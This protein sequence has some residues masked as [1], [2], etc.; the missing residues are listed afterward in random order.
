VLPVPA[1]F[2]LRTPVAPAPDPCGRCDLCVRSCPVGALAA[3]G[4]LEP[5]R[6]LQSLATRTGRFSDA[7]RDAWGT[8]LYGCQDCQSCCPHNRTLSEI[9]PSAEG[10]LGPSIPLGPFLGLDE[11]GRSAYLRGTALGAS[12]IPPVSLLRNALVAAGSRADP[13]VKPLVSR[14]AGSGDESVAAAAR[15]ALRR[16]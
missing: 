16:L 3:S 8:R 2:F 7:V 9:A 14:Y 13:V 10:E 6:C 1:A 11:A 5:D 12:W 15:W 4:I